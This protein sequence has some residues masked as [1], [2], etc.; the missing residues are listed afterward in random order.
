MRQTSSINWWSINSSEQPLSVSKLRVAI[1]KNNKKK[2][3]KLCACCGLQ[4]AAPPPD[5]GSPFTHLY[6]SSIISGP[7]T[8]RWRGSL[9]CNRFCDEKTKRKKK[10]QQFKTRILRSDSKH[11]RA[12]E[13]IITVKYTT[14]AAAPGEPLFFGCFVFLSLPNGPV[15]GAQRINKKTTSRTFRSCQPL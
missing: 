14:L 9:R 11:W 1:A 5:A 2:K 12:D 4:D 8:R 10:Q 13:V 15:K 6:F 7:A 3:N